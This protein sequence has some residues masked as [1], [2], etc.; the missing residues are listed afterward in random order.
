MK[1]RDRILSTINHIEA[2][3]VPIGFD[4]AGNLLSKVLKYYGVD[5]LWKLYEKTGIDCFSVW[6]WPV[7]QPYYIGPRCDEN[8]VVK[9][10]QATYK[11]WGKVGQEEYPLTN[12]SIDEYL[13]PN[14]DHFDFS[15]LKKDLQNLQQMDI[16]TASGH[17]GVGFQHHVEMSSY[18]K[19]FYEL[20]DDGWMK[21]YIARTREFFI[22]YFNK[23]F[24]EADGMIDI[25]RADEDLGGQHNMMISPDMWRK[26]YKPLWKE[27][28]DICKNNGAKIWLHSCGYCRPIVDDFIEIGVDI[29]NPIPPYVK[30]S[31]PLDMKQTYGDRLCFDGGVD[32][33]NIIVNG[34]PQQVHNEVKLRIEQ[35]AQGGGYIVS[36]SQVFSQDVPLENAIAFFEV[37]LIH[38]EY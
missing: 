29:L 5:E 38:G 33:M 32:Q 23:L 11:C 22:S 24:L 34:T 26:W 1:R 16:T 12:T 15:N 2:D 35:M 27:V 19:I 36:P 6:T 17:A 4:M 14:I 25:I 9:G 37:A 8:P 31:N 30:D 28:F 7:A 13:W 10:S 21:E 3:K 18:D 20:L